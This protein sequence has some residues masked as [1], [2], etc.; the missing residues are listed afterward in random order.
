MQNL[1][2]N[3]NDFIFLKYNHYHD[4]MGKGIKYDKR[5]AAAIEKF[6]QIIDTID[7]S[8]ENSL[9]WIFLIMAILI[10]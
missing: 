8:Q 5:R 10:L 7:F 9:F 1:P 3:T 2:D 4:V 6:K